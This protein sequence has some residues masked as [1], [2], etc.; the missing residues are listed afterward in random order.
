M[1]EKDLSNASFTF[2]KGLRNKLMSNY[3]LSTNNVVERFF[4][5]IFIKS[6]TS[7][8]SFYWFESGFIPV[9]YIT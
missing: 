8:P 2:I 5:F 7:A 9:S 6:N 4:A 1:K 3:S